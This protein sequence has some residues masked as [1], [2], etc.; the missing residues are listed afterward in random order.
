[1][2][3][4]CSEKKDITE[5]NQ[6]RKDH[7]DEEVWLQGVH[8][9]EAHLEGAYLRD[10]HLEGAILYG[11]HL[12]NANLMSAYL[13]GADLL[14]VYLK[15]AHLEAANLERTSFYR[16][17]LRGVNFGDANLKEADLGEAT[18][19]GATLHVTSLEGADFGAAIVDGSTSIMDCEIDRKTDFRNVG[20]DSARIDPG[21]KQL[22]KCNGRRMNWQGWYK[23]QSGKESALRLLLTSP[24]R[25]F[26]WISD[27]GR[28]T[29]RILAVFLLLALLFANIYYYWDSPGIISNLFEGKEGLVPE[30]LVPFRAIYFSIVT[31]TTLG[32]GDMHANCRSFWGHALLMIQ[33]LLGYILLAALVT[34]FAVLFTAGGPAGKFAKKW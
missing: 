34:R 32:F 21:M 12:E 24:V 22:L 5:W 25:A 20:L 2:L 27:Y 9:G 23:G 26:W 10:A 15:D 11:A 7:P 3:L 17:M 33:V 29:W 1:M 18:L 16:A 8:L 19:E 13:E 4:R 6:W 28:L 30:W 14:L 31:M